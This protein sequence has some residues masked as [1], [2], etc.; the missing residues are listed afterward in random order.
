[1]DENKFAF[2]LGMITTNVI[3][4]YKNEMSISYEEAY[5]RF[6]NSKLYSMLEKEDTK[7]W[8]FSRWALLRM[9]KEEMENGVNDT[10]R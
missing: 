1:M 10:G 2:I 6:Y 3:K 9:F 8:Y 5:K 4:D 7:M